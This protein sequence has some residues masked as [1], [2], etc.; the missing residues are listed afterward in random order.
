M[1]TDDGIAPPKNG[2]QFQSLTDLRLFSPPS[3]VKVYSAKGKY[4]RTEDPTYWEDR[5]KH[6]DITRYNGRTIPK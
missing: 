3:S 2:T 5:N 4:L 1:R 6:N